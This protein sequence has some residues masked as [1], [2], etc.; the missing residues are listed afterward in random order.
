MDLFSNFFESINFFLYFDN[1]NPKK[2]DFCAKRTFVPGKSGKR[3]SREK[4][5]RGSVLTFQI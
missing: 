5:K 3:S 2:P 1:K 4:I